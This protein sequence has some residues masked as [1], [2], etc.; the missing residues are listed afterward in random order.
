MPKNLPDIIYRLSDDNKFIPVVDAE[1]SLYEIP[2]AKSVDYFSNVEAY[3][4]FIK[5]VER[6]VRT[7]NRYR[8]YIYY[9][10][11]VVGLK[12]CQ[13][14]S[15]IIPDP[16]GKIEL[17]MH[18]GPIFTL[19]NYVQIVLEW[20]LIKN[21][22]VTTFRIADTILDEHCKY[23]NIQVVMLLATIHE[24]VHNRNI[25]INYKQAFGNLNEFVKKYGEAIF[26]E[27]KRKLN[28]YIDRSLIQDSSDFG[29]L[30]LN[31]AILKHV[32]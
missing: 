7:N 24:E 5:D 18:H 14:M 31:D 17:E 15:D 28:M 25:F 2:F 29:V 26:P 22:K 32:E 19:Y 27:L 1:T 4:R 20:Y 16:D 21:K 3:D 12:N 30:K 10:K 8:K 11:N 6:A 9:L 13:V 23:N